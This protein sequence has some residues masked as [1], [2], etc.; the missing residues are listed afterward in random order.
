ARIALDNEPSFLV[1]DDAFQHSD[2]NRRE[3]LVPQAVGLV[4]AGWQVLYFTIDDHIRDLFNTVG[5]RYVSHSL[6]EPSPSEDR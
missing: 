2:W 1:L 5:D 4:E 3:Q 6:S